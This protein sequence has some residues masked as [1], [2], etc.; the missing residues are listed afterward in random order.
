MSDQPTQE[1]YRVRG[2]LKL[3]SNRK[4]P[5]SG[6]MGRLLA[7]I[8][9]HFSRRVLTLDD[10]FLFPS[11]LSTQAIDSY[12]TRMAPST[13]RNFA[14]DVADGLP[15][16]NSHRTGGFAVETELPIGRKF[17]AEIEGQFLEPDSTGFDDQ[18]GAMVATWNY[19]VRGITISTLSND[20]IIEA[21]ETG[22]IDDESVGFSIR[23]DGQ[24]ICG[25]CGN[26][27]L[28]YEAC[29]HFP[30][31]VYEDFEGNEARGFIWI[32]DGHAIEGSLVYSGATPGAV[33]RKAQEHAED[34]STDVLARLEDA[35]QV[36]LKDP[37]RTV[38]LPKQSKS[39]AADSQP[40]DVPEEGA[41]ENPKKEETDMPIFE[42]LTAIAEEREIVFGD[43]ITNETDPVEIVRF[44]VDALTQRTDALSADAELGRA[45]RAELIEAIH[46][47]RV[48]AQGEAYTEAHRGQY[49]T[50]LQAAALDYLRAELKQ[51]TE[52]A[53]QVLEAGSGAS[54]K[55]DETPIVSSTIYQ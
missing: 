31:E 12:G 19:I 54:R 55:T 18:I 28:D 25:V 16:M 36:R 35:Y 48:Q 41:R 8:N 39:R 43:G 30:F 3:A 42:D 46:R 13:I 45:H 17:D 50:I 15:L 27:Y 49:D 40:D 24:Y 33:I 20:D 22:T 47:A 7:R 53:E 1:L 21:V 14:Q 38:L 9:T 5:N 44:I 32:E 10:L 6:E 52:R 4:E 26:D 51:W 2:D 34:L 37:N 23:P 29:P 11:V